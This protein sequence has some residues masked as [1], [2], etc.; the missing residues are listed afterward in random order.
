MYFIIQNQ[1]RF[2]QN[3]SGINFFMPL[4]GKYFKNTSFR[5]KP[6]YHCFQHESNSIT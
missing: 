2:A 5:P 1:S 4:D 3:K 6:N